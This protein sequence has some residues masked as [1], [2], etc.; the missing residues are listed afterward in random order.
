MVLK[1]VSPADAVLDLVLQARSPVIISIGR[2]SHN[3]LR[4]IAN[5]VKIVV[6]LLLKNGLKHVVILADIDIVRQ[7]P[8]IIPL[9]PI[10]RPP[11]LARRLSGTRTNVG[12]T[13][14]RM[15]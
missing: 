7:V 12:T 6:V 14:K 3:G 13:K 10:A 5:V 2:R 4:G 9:V 8:S 1:K 15:S 11:A